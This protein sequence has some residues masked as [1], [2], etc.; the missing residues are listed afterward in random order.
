MI[1][2]VHCLLCQASSLRGKHRGLEL[3]RNS[4]SLI[5]APILNSMR[6]KKPKKRYWRAN[7]NVF[8]HLQEVFFFFVINKKG[9]NPHFS[10]SNTHTVSLLWLRVLMNTK[11]CIC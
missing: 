7:T 8:Y 11:V 4:G 6:N 3:S 9:L 5:P 1:G 2:K 10:I